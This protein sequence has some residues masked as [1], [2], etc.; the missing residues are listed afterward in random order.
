MLPSMPTMP[1]MPSL[2]NLNLPAL[3]GR[4]RQ[5]FDPYSDVPAP[6]ILPF[7]QGG[8]ATRFFASQPPSTEHDPATRGIWGEPSSAPLGHYR[9]SST[10]RAQANS[11]QPSLLLRSGVSPTSRPQI[12]HPFY[13]STDNTNADGEWGKSYSP[14]SSLASPTSSHGTLTLTNSN[15]PP[16]GTR[17]LLAR[18]T[19]TTSATSAYSGSAPI[20]LDN[21]SFLDFPAPSESRGS[22]QSGMEFLATTPTSACLST[23]GA[24]STIIAKLNNAG[25]GSDGNYSWSRPTSEDQGGHS[26]VDIFPPPLMDSNVD[27]TLLFSAND[28]HSSSLFEYGTA[29]P[30]TA[31]RDTSSSIYTQPVGSAYATA[32]QTGYDQ[33]MYSTVSSGILQP[34]KRSSA[35][36]TATRQSSQSQTSGVWTIDESQRGTRAWYDHPDI[37]EWDEGLARDSGRTA[38]MAKRKSSK[39]AKSVTWEDGTVG[40]GMPRAL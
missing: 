4:Q 39:S 36:T 20:P 9:P 21:S 19:S 2:P 12:S 14:A 1:S 29:T 18:N 8:W 16:S 17:T 40:D 10:I 25:I 27:S 32:G 28:L 24:K 31:E 13:T 35:A 15:E 7:G 37:P 5:D 11:S 23:A 33:T 6:T 30:N 3:I 22:Y 34:E 26:N 38:E